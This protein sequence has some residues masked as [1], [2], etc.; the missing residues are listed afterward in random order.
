MYQCHISNKF[1][2]AVVY[3]IVLVLFTLDYDEKK[4]YHDDNNHSADGSEDENHNCYGS[5]DLFQT[6]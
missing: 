2:F 1:S 3:S 6:I 4:P 5:V